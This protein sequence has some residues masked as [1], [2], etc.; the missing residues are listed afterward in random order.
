MEISSIEEIVEYLKKNKRFLYDRFGVT[1]MGIFGSFVR[2]DQ[3]ASSDIDMIVD[4]EKARKNIHS[5]LQLKRYLEKELEK[6]IDIGFEHSL[7]PILRDKIKK[8]VIY[9]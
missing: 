7:K 8:Q 2:G 4:I 6:K 1:R 9:V 3:V 5:F